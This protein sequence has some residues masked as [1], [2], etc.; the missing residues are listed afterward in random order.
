M[1]SS[2]AIMPILTSTT[3]TPTN[4]AVPRMSRIQN[5]A[6]LCVPL[7]ATQR[8]PSRHVV[9]VEF[10]RKPPTRRAARAAWTLYV[11]PPLALALPLPLPCPPLPLP[12]PQLLPSPLSQ[13]PPPSP[14]LRSPPLPLSFPSLPFPYSLGSQIMLATWGRVILFM[15]YAWWRDASGPQLP[16]TFDFTHDLN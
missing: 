16:S 12:L 7:S 5:V 13:A 4:A 6:H 14:P 9:L 3:C 1:G 2:G 11:T 8:D 10:V 15:T